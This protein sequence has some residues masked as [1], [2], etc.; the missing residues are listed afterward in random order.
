VLCIILS[1]S[2]SPKKARL[3]KSR[4]VWWAGR[5]ARIVK[6]VEDFSGETLR[7]ETSW[8]TSA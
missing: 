8:K 4:T 1:V 2:S 3:I 5:V 7:K 6:Y